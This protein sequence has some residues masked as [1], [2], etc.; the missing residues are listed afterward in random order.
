MKAEL[1]DEREFNQEGQ[2]VRESGGCTSHA[3]RITA[4]QWCGRCHG[5]VIDCKNTGRW[6]CVQDMAGY[7]GQGAQEMLLH[8]EKGGKDKIW[9]IWPWQ[10]TTVAALD[11]RNQ[12]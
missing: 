6:K 1:H 5:S 11:G 4:A 10:P 8:T 7:H 3:I 2:E 9:E 12:M